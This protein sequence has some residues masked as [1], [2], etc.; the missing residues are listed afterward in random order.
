MNVVALLVHLRHYCFT[1][2]K[3]DTR[4]VLL[5]LANAQKNT[6]FV[7]VTVVFKE[8]RFLSPFMRAIFIGSFCRD[9]EP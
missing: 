5:M 7:G 4:T 8:A 9:S 1:A 2:E 3:F 6:L